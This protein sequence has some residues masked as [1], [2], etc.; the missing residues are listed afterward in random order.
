[1]SKMKL[2]IVVILAFALVLTVVTISMAAAEKE[3]VPQPKGFPMTI[4][5]EKFDTIENGEV[6]RDRAASKRKAVVSTSLQF[7]A[8]KKVKFAQTGC[9][10][11]TLVMNAPDGN[12]DA[13]NIDVHGNPLRIY[14]DE[15]LAG[16]YTECLRKVPLVVAEAGEELTITVFTSN[17]MGAKYDKIII[18]YTEPL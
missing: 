6:V 9:Y 8:T 16:T 4:Q 14:P 3:K 13:I 17:E 12:T 11:I 1:M 18:T 10:E 15:R 2:S 7:K 5:L